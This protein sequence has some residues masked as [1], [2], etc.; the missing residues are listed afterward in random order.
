MK[1]YSLVVI[2]VIVI[3]VSFLRSENRVP[4]SITTDIELGE[5]FERDT[6]TPSITITNTSSK[7]LTCIGAE[8]KCHLGCYGPL[9]EIPL[10]LP[11]GKS[12]RLR[13]Q[14]KTPMIATLQ[15]RGIATN[16]FED[17]MKLF[18]DAADQNVVQ[19]RIHGRVI[20]R[21]HSETPD[22]SLPVEPGLLSN[23]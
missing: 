3:C 16:E 9:D 4:L 2:C 19:L 21:P 20:E 22:P 1:T 7:M 6:L 13:L 12:V 8:E 10:P 23:R 17:V 11:P 5:V 14:Y 15:K 18:F